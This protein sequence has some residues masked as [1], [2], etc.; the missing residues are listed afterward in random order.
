MGVSAHASLR[1]GFEVT[2]D[3][4]WETWEHTDDFLSCPEGHTEGAKK[5]KHCS[6]CGAKFDFQK[7]ETTGPTENFKKFCESI[8]APPAS[9]IPPDEDEWTE[10]GVDGLDVFCSDGYSDADTEE[11]SWALG[12]HIA[13]TGDILHMEGGDAVPFDKALA[14]VKKVETVRNSLGLQDR[15]VH[16]FLLGSCSY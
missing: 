1:V 3:D 15:P 9:S 13:R 7:R 16:V 14:A 8:G 11:T 6:D 12:L 5:G 10:G 2:H 4:F